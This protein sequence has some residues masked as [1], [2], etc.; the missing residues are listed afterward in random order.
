MKSGYFTIMWNGRDHRASEMNDHQTCQS[1]VSS[2]D[3]DVVKMLGLERSPL[4]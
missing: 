2:K 4:V 1:L 3:G